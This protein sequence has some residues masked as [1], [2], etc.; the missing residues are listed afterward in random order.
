MTSNIQYPPRAERAKFIEDYLKE[1]GVIYLVRPEF[2]DAY[3]R[4]FP[5]YVKQPSMSAEHDSF[6]RRA[7]DDLNWMVT[8]D[9][10]SATRVTAEEA[11]SI[12]VPDALNATRFR[13]RV[14]NP[15]LA[16]TALA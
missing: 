8:E 11:A 6:V 16:R 10:V 15:F 14:K 1:H 12:G 3:A 13:L 2:F 9:L 7:Y 5:M 4:N